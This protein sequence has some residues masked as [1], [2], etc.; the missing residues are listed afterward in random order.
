MEGLRRIGATL[1]KLWLAGCFVVLFLAFF[2]FFWICFITHYHRGAYVI[3]IIF[4][5][6]VA[7]CSGLFPRVRNYNASRRFS[8]PVVF[9]CNHASYLDILLFPVIFHQTSIFIAKS[10]L[11]KIPLFNMFFKYLDI[12]VD[13]K[14]PSSGKA[15]LEEAAKRLRSGEHMIIFP[16]GTITSS[17]KLIPFKN[18]PFKLAL[19][20]QVPIVPLAFKNNWKYL[21]N[22][23]FFKSL[24]QPGFP[25]LTIGKPI[26]TD[27][28]NTDSLEE[29]K[30]KVY[31]FMQAHTLSQ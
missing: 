24:G 31:T 18:G 8:T 17:G 11:L 16:E 4:S 21:Q 7:A 30:Q 19:D 3:K 26:L 27:A 5:S 15:A 29:I 9:V 12:P 23:G 13:R 6:L 14:R 1:W 2:P 20:T 22:G 28:S 10:E 25:T